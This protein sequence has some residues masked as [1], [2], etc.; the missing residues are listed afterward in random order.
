MKVL[1]WRRFLRREDG[2]V[3]IETAIMVSILLVL[4][5]GIVD[6]GRAMFT[7]NNLVSAAREAA[8]FGA[9]YSLPSGYT[10]MVD[11]TQKIAIARFSPYGTTALTASN[12][13]VTCS[14]SC[15]APSG[16]SIKVVITY[17]YSWLTPVWRFLRWGTTT[18]FNSTTGVS[19]FHA[20]AEYRYEL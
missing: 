19:Q 18:N 15:T 16:G 4:V 10:G 2:N 8:R 3:L 9:S 7:E 12:V 17:S 20:Q 1:R 14:A 11:S 6:F 5:F 13:A